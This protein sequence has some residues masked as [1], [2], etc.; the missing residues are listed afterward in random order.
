MDEVLSCLLVF[1]GLGMM[2]WLVL[3]ILLLFYL[4]FD[5]FFRGG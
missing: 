3:V 1:G 4:F 5:E 2:I